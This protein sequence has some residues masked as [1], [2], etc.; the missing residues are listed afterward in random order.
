MRAIKPGTM[1]IAFYVDTPPAEFVHYDGPVPGP[2]DV[3]KYDILP[4]SPYISLKSEAD[5]AST[6]RSRL[7]EVAYA[8]QSKLAE[9]LVS[10]YS[11]AERDSWTRLSEEAKAC[12]DSAYVVVGEYMQ[13]EIDATPGLTAQI[14]AD[15]VLAKSAAYRQAL[16]KLKGVRST[17]T[18]ELDALTDAQ[19]LTVDASTITSDPR[20][21][22]G[23]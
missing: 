22:T 16:A 15:R 2:E 7:K 4:S 12:K 19:I 21:V 23:A 8:H 10:S 20:W 6:L 13:E 3:H 5:L 1:E 18:A 14:L 17:I 11:T 9:L